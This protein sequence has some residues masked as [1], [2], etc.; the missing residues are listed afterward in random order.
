M[1]YTKTVWVDGTNAFTPTS[2]DDPKLNAENLNK[3]EQGIYDNAV[4][5]AELEEYRQSGVVSATVKNA[6]IG[7]FE[8]CAYIDTDAS[9]ASN[10]AILES[11]AAEV[12]SITLSSSTLTFSGSGTQTLTA[13]VDPSGS[14]VT[15]TSS[16]TSVAT[17]SDGVV[18]S[19]GNGTCVITAAAGNLSA[20]C[21]VTVSGMTASHTIT[22]SLTRVTSDNS[23]TTATDNSAYT[24]NITAD[25]SYTLAYVTVTMGGVDVTST[26]YDGAGAISIAS[27][28]GDVVITAEA[29]LHYWDFTTSTDDVISGASPTI[30][31][32]T[33]DSDG[34]HCS[35]LTDNINLGSV[36]TGG[37]YGQTFEIKF[38][39]IVADTSVFNP[40]NVN[41]Y[42][43]YVKGSSNFSNSFGWTNSHSSPWHT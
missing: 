42:L 16:D 35:A 7:L 5:I 34:I 41:V 32:A 37:G 43:F 6:I 2:E 38:G 17:V 31:G 15:W 24:A 39:D 12:T 9:I 33:R 28:T 21:S 1:S 3:I 4:D 8:K 13:T 23:A 26:V 19:V 10:L 40:S 27:V 18:T 11:W 25:G 14:T 20:T 36:L 29:D 30:T 22:N